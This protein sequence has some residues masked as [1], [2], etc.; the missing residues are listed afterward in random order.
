MSFKDRLERLHDSRR[1][2]KERD[3]AAGGKD[4]N[5][6]SVFYADDVDEASANGDG[7]AS[8][9]ASGTEQHTGSTPERGGQ[10]V[11]RETSA[12]GSDNAATEKPRESQPSE[13]HTEKPRGEVYQKLERSY[14][15]K[16]KSRS[17]S[18][19]TGRQQSSSTERAAKGGPETGEP[20]H[21]EAEPRESTR[22]D[23]AATTSGGNRGPTTDDVGTRVAELRRQAR[24]AI[25]RGDWTTAAPRLHEIVALIPNHPYALEQLAVYHDRRDEPRAAERYRE[26]LER[27]SPFGN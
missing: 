6:P 3:E 7:D 23:S 5:S 20:Q 10:H 16:Q 21:G 18:E 13:S 1:R 15:M 27:Q 22:T 25:D 8:K 11:S 9:E 26:R 4:E 19:P 14:S 2:Q 24:E 12:S 17:A